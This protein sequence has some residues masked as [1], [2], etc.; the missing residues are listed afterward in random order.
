VVR[1]ITPR[2]ANS[3]QLGRKV[4]ELKK[5]QQR[6]LLYFAHFFF[7]SSAAIASSNAITFD[8]IYNCRALA[9]LSNSRAS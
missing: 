7:L 8:L 2:L 1:E 9:L 4:R 6:L 5:A 3:L